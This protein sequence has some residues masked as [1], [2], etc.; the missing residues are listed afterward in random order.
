[1]AALLNP[2][3]RGQFGVANIKLVPSR[4]CQSQAKASERR[5]HLRSALFRDPIHL[6]QFA[7]CPE[8]AFP[9]ECKVFSMI[10]SVYI[11][12]E[13]LGRNLH[14]CLA[15]LCTIRIARCAEIAFE[16]EGLVAFQTRNSL[17]HGSRLL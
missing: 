2:D 10:K 6:P 7:A 9:I 5:K 4:K 15:C 3:Q 11:N 17:K 16:I 14:A 1:M 13:L 12:L 8:N